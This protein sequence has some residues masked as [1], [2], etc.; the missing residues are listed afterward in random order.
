MKKNYKTKASKFRDAFGLIENFKV[1]GIYYSC[2]RENVFECLTDSE[3]ELW[4]SL[5]EENFEVNRKN[6]CRNMVDGNDPKFNDLTSK[7]LDLAE[8][9]YIEYVCEE[10]EIRYSNRTVVK[11]GEMLELINKMR[12][13]LKS[14]PEYSPEF[15]NLDL[16][17]NFLGLN[18]VKKIKP[19]L[20][21]GGFIKNKAG[22]FELIL[23]YINNLE[24]GLYILPE[25]NNF[26]FDLRYSGCFNDS[27]SVF[28]DYNSKYKDIF[29][30]SI[31]DYV[32]DFESQLNEYL[33]PSY[34]EDD[35][36]YSIY[37]VYSVAE[38]L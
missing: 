2:N 20:S 36:R 19:V 17:M 21:N 32:Y 5:W 23:E 1:I 26:R 33:N 11:I 6:L 7:A 3:K 22:D 30:N 38:L 4:N 15:Y 28:F 10:G 34:Y 13:E 16:E 24:P 18:S 27:L 14:L 8:E 37:D 29:I 25:L 31:K 9:A 12:E 35:G